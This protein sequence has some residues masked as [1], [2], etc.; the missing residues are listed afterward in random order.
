MNSDSTSLLVT[1]CFNGNI[2][3]V[4][5]LINDSSSTINVNVFIIE[6]HYMLSLACI[7]KKSRATISPACGSAIGSVLIAYKDTVDAKVICEYFYILSSEAP[8]VVSTIVSLF[9]NEL[10][11]LVVN[12]ILIDCKLQPNDTAIALITNCASGF[13]RE[14]IKD[15]FIICCKLEQP[16]LLESLLKQHCQA[17]ESLF[18][19]DDP[20]AQPKSSFHGITEFCRNSDTET[21]RVF[22]NRYK[23]LTAHVLVA[24]IRTSDLEIAKLI[25]EDYGNL[26]TADHIIKGFDMACKRNDLDMMDL[27][28]EHDRRSEAGILN[29]DVVDLSY[30][31]VYQSLNTVVVNHVSNF[32]EVLGN[33]DV[34]ETLFKFCAG[35]R[36]GFTIDSPSNRQLANALNLSYKILQR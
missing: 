17:I 7:R 11:S 10:T 27:F 36:C 26:L 24:S 34:R 31:Q 15:A 4:E 22:V 12:S 23:Q 32:L 20:F 35:D 21:A 25:L 14:A 19:T 18:A 5:A 28:V 9:A 2:P 16:D 33:D 1:A 13:D 8:T 30:D 6:I 3:Q 29:L